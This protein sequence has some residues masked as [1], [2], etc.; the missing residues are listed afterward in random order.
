MAVLREHGPMVWA[1]VPSARPPSVGLTT[2]PVT[3]RLP[4]LG[5]V[6]PGVLTVTLALCVG[7]TGPY[8]AET[9][10]TCS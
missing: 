3:S 7:R 9:L 1:T 8:D 6:A 4:T 2:G 10:A 5:S